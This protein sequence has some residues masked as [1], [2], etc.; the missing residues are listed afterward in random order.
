MFYKRLRAEQ[1]TLLTALHRGMPLA[2]A[3]SVA[4]ESPGSETA[5]A[6]RHFHLVFG[7]GRPWA[8]SGG[9]KMCIESSLGETVHGRIH[10]R[11]GESTG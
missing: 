4:M 8:G 2:K 5:Q 7:T 3:C 6:G 9:I 11:G 10:S 1:F